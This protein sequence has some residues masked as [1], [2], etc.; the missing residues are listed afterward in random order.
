M[1]QIFLI[2]ISAKQLPVLE[3]IS[4]IGFLQEQYPRE[5]AQGNMALL[6]QQLAGKVMRIAWKLSSSNLMSLE[7]SSPLH[8]RALI[9][10]SRLLPL[11]FFHHRRQ[12]AGHVS[13]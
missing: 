8:R 12:S 10:S 5:A 2:S 4:N 11:A 13:Y 7:E 9:L 3:E 1:W 6:S